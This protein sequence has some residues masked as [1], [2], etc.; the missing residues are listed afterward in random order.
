M[1]RWLRTGE[2]DEF[3]L[4]LAKKGLKESE[5]A[6]KNLEAL[7][8]IGWAAWNLEGINQLIKDHER[9]IASYKVAIRQEM[10]KQ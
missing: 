5:E 8:N 6:I 1:A 7:K 2:K 10:A 4:D 3:I 9:K